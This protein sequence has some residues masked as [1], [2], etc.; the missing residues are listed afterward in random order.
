[1]NW[2]KNKTLKSGWFSQKTSL[3][4]YLLLGWIS[5]TGTF[6][7]SLMTG[8]YFNLIYQESSSKSAIL[9]NFG[10]NV[11]SIRDFFLLM[12]G[13]L[14]LKVLSHFYERNGLQ[15]KA[16]EFNFRLINRLYQKQLA[17]DSELFNAS[18]FG[19]YLL[20]YSGDLQPIRSMLTNGIHRGIKDLLFIFTGLAL[21]L[22][23]NTH[24]TL[25]LIAA[26]FLVAPVVWAIDQKQKPWIV[27]KRAKK[28][29]LLNYVT[30]T[31][32]LHHSYT[33]QRQKDDV[34]RTFKQKNHQALESNVQYQTLESLRLAWLSIAG[35][36]LVFGLLGSITLIP[37]SKGSPGELLAFLLVTG[38]LVPAMRNVAKAPNLISKG[39]LSLNK[40]ERLL[41][42]KNKPV[43]ETAKLP[44]DS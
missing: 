7:L 27:E 19:K 40:I 43:T 2:I 38:S 33:S 13:I 16:A 37:N 39:M 1:M 30:S 6:L 32:S 15:K 21:L 22:Y 9:S 29:I 25:S 23:L 17:W 11:Y 24:W 4:L 26:A 8:W 41:R 44:V 18:P 20:R 14:F 34:V 12:G 3:A 5:S 28:S 31:F 36:L 10:L 35:P 42:K